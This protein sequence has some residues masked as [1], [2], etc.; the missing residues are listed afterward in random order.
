M[1][2]H[3]PR[4]PES[5]NVAYGPWAEWRE[6]D[7]PSSDRPARADHHAAV[8]SA[9]AMDC[10]NAPAPSF[11]RTREPSARPESRRFP[12][13]AEVSRPMTRATVTTCSLNPTPTRSPSLH[14]RA[15]LTPTTTPP[16]G[17]TW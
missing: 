11:V 2:G 13:A 1:G 16:P 15:A 10:E 6:P 17:T 4:D 8:S 5:E 12:A 14:P 7:G 9:N 3:E